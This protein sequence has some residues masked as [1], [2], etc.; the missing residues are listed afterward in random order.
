MNCLYALVF[1]AATAMAITPNDI[2]PC[3]FEVMTYTTFYSGGSVLTTSTDA[4]YHDHD[5]LW[6]WDSEFDGIPGIIDAHEWSVIWRPDDGA[7]YHN[8]GKVC[9]KNNNSTKM[10]PYPFDWIASKLDNLVWSEKEVKYGDEDAK[11]YTGVGISSRFKVTATLNLFFLRKSNMFVFGN[12]TV[13]G[14]LIDLELEMAVNKYNPN[15]AIP[16]AMFMPAVPACPATT[17]PADPSPDFQRYCYRK[18]SS[19]ASIVPNGLFFLATLLAALLIFVA[20]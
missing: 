14:S 7:S 2:L 17:M 6:R 12:G 10:Y 8:N 5:N 3:A 20:V 1:L 13:E 18:E 4:L 15:A 9:L 11:M 16:G 19:G